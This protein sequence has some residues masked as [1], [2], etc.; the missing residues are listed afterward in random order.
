[1]RIV[2]FSNS[3]LPSTQAN[4]IHVMNMASALGAIG[5]EVDLYALRGDPQPPENSDRPPHEKITAHYGVE[6]CFDIRFY[7]QPPVFGR[8]TVGAVDAIIRQHLAKVDLVIGRD[9]KTCALAALTG[10]PVL[11]ETHQPIAHYPPVDRFLLRRALARRAFRGVVTISQPLQDILCDETGAG[12]HYVLVAHDAA[13]DPPTLPEKIRKNERPIIGYTGHLYAGRGIEVIVELANRM[14]QADF[15]I[16]GGAEA[17]VAAWQSRT[18][19]LA[20]IQFTGFLAPSSAALSRLQCDVLLA[21]YQAN[22]SI[23]GGAQTAK[24]M[25]PLKIFEYMASGV[26]FV[27]SDLP[28]LHEILEDRRNCLF[29]DPTDVDAWE[30]AI[31]SL[32]SDTAA[33]A[34][35]ARVASEDFREHYT[36]RARARRLVEFATAPETQP[37]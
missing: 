3:H 32:L 21:P 33:A 9:A 7:R 19:S 22:T 5:H 30:R 34:T 23:P 27:C 2:Y 17:D 36:W 1:M 37:T 20:N 26:P 28:V 25:S 31:T 29:V 11:F 6:N 24:W 13:A 8:S 16:M 15:L 12:R 4:S 18:D 14:P 10:L 35:I